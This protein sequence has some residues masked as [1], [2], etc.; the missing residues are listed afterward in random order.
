MA[1]IDP[2]WKN[3]QKWNRKALKFN[4]IPDWTSSEIYNSKTDQWKQNNEYLKMA[5]E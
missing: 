2:G 5:I 1:A 3:D 4:C